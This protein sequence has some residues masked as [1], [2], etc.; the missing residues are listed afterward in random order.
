MSMEEISARA[1]YGDDVGITSQLALNFLADNWNGWIQ[2]DRSGDDAAR[3]WL[4]QSVSIGLNNSRLTVFHSDG[5]SETLSTLFSA[6]PSTSFRSEYLTIDKSSAGIL[7]TCWTAGSSSYVSDVFAVSH[8]RTPNDESLLGLVLRHGE[9]SDFD[10]PA[11]VF[12]ENMTSDDTYTPVLAADS[13][14]FTQIVKI[15]PPYSM[16]YFISLGMVIIGT[17]SLTPS[18]GIPPI[19]K[20][21]INDST[22]FIMHGI[23][24]PC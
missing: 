15:Y 14:Y 21:Q 6:V 23:A 22:Y 7:V 9:E 3:L 24:L 4:S 11:Y 12:T 10:E 2:I 16:D 8:I 19:A 20:G 17:Y 13:S 5:Y 1:Y 18:G